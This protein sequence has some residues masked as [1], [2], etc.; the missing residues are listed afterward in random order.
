VSDGSR[1]G[2]QR[3]T[4]DT[5]LRGVTR[6]DRDRTAD[7]RRSR[8][9]NIRQ[10]RA[11]VTEA[12]NTTAAHCERFFSGHAVSRLRDI[13]GLER[14]LTR[15]PEFE[16]LMVGPGPRTKLWTYVTLGCWDAV[17]TDSGHGLEFFLIAPGQDGRHLLT[18]GMAAYY[19]GGPSSQRLDHG[20]TVPIGEPWLEGSRCDHLLVSVPYPFGPQ[21]EWCE[22]DGGHARLLWMVP[23]TADEREFKATYGLEALEQRFDDAG[24]RYWEAGRASII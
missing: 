14:T 19:H 20:H 12:S 2:V 15:V 8:R 17:H 10:W 24:L 23:I 6:L 3:R 7:R 13:P 9:A 22:W 16:A 4:Q 21:L 5:G 11:A 1:V 18:L